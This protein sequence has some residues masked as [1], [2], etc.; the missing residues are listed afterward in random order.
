MRRSTGDS[1]R[2]DGLHDILILKATRRPRAKP[3]TLPV[4]PPKRRCRRSETAPASTAASTR[5]GCAGSWRFFSACPTPALRSAK[6]LLL[7]RT[8]V[9]V[10]LGTNDQA[11]I[12]G[13]F[14]RLRRSLACLKSRVLSSP[15]ERFYRFEDLTRARLVARPAVERVAS[16]SR[17]ERTSTR[18]LMHISS[19]RSL[20]TNSGTSNTLTLVPRREAT[21]TTIGPS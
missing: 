4:R 3:Q 2:F 6:R 17:P 8:D 15:L 5:H 12:V 21:G 11:D 7:G 1:Y 9:P 14:G 18:R 19:M 20:L 16:I 13:G 10:R